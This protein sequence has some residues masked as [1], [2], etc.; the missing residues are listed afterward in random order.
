[1]ESESNYSSSKDY[2]E[3]YSISE[4]HIRHLY[5]HLNNFANAPPEI[6]VQMKNGEGIQSSSPD[7]IF[8]DHQLRSSP[9]ERINIRVSTMQ[10]DKLLL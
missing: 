6:R 9:I 3:A 7:A 10:D 5:D 1:M 2:N 4:P 8:S